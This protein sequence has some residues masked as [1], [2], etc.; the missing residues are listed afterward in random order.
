LRETCLQA[1]KASWIFSG[2]DLDFCRQRRAR[3]HTHPHIEPDPSAKSNR[4]T[5]TRPSGSPSRNSRLLRSTKAGSRRGRSSPARARTRDR[6]QSP[7]DVRFASKSGG[8]ADV[9][10]GPSRARSRLVPIGPTKLAVDASVRRWWAT[11]C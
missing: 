10:G 9:P 5:L 11:Q 3:T 1:L 2:E 4:P 6:S 7:I 8:K